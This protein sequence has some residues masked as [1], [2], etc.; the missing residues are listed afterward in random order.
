MEPWYMEYLQGISR[1]FVIEG[2]EKALAEHDKENEEYIETLQETA[3]IRAKE[4]HALRKLINDTCCRAQKAKGKPELLEDLRGYCANV[5][6]LQALGMRADRDS[7]ENI[8]KPRILPN[9]GVG[10]MTISREDNTLGGQTVPPFNADGITVDNW[11]GMLAVRKRPVIVHAAQIHFPE[12]FEVTTKEGK[13]RGKPGDYLM[14]GV[15]GEKYPID[16]EI[17]E[18]TYDILNPVSRPDLP[19]QKDD[20]S[21]TDLEGS[22]K[23]SNWQCEVCGEINEGNSACRNGCETKAMKQFRESCKPFKI[24]DAETSKPLCNL[25]PEEILQ[26]LEQNAVGDEW[27]VIM[28]LRILLT[29]NRSGVMETNRLIEKVAALETLNGSQAKSAIR[30]ATGAEL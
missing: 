8:C 9:E 22:N 18:R 5:M 29:A 12:G 21:P 2:F 16:R 10:K 17:F 6:P 11:E 24:C 30:R 26:R 23:M 14:I 4:T 27:S 7:A 25:T 3:L 1:R 19:G 13:L 28:L 20:S 15:A